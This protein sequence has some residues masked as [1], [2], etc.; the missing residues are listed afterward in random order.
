MQSCHQDASLDGTSGGRGL[1][2]RVDGANKWGCQE[3]QRGG[4]RTGAGSCDGRDLEA[5]GATRGRRAATRGVA[6][7]APA[8]ER[9]HKPRDSAAKEAPHQAGGLANQIRSSTPEGQP[10]G[11]D[12]P[13]AGVC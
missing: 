13:G 11:V 12:A 4:P 5:G 1:A 7:I 3:G 10:S 9:R 2:G 8:G 6:C